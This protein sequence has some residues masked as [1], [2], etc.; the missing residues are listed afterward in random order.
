MPADVTMT[1]R[2]VGTEYTGEIDGV[3]F[4]GKTF[5]AMMTLV[6]LRL[7]EHPDLGLLLRRTER[8]GL[9][10][11]RVD[12]DKL[13]LLRTDPARYIE[14]H[15]IAPVTIDLSG[16]KKGQ[17]GLA[18]GER[19]TI[20][21]HSGIRAGYDTIAEAFGNVVYARIRNN[22]VESPDTGRWVSLQ[23]LE[24]WLNAVPVGVITPALGWVGI[25][26]IDLLRTKNSRFYLPREWNPY[27]GW[28]TKEQLSELLEQFEEE[29]VLLCQSAE[30]VTTS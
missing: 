5:A 1:Y 9:L 22:N 8:P 10:T 13:D 14:M 29:K 17:R 23:V 20:P 6:H 21:K 12:G 4:T 16:G 25:R 28:I 19:T 11:V 3:P 24:N 30:T 27:Q 15:T 26:I 18:R 2:R 7:V